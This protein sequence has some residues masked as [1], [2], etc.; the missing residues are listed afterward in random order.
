MTLKKKDKS[1]LINL[2]HE[3]HDIHDN[4]KYGIPKNNKFIRQHIK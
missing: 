4:I 2:I 3:M 1:F